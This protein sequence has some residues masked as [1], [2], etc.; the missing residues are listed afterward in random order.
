MGW[1][2]RTTFGPR[3][4]MKWHVNV[5]ALTKRNKRSGIWSKTTF[6]L[7]MMIALLLML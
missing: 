3:M 2:R 6:Q 7:C 5:E 4:S 1:P